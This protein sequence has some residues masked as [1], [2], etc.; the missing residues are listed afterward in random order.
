[1]KKNLKKRNKKGFTLIELV[2]VIAIL[3]ILAAI[4]VPVISGFIETANQSAD[5]ANARLVY[6]AAA[7][8]FAANNTASTGTLAASALTPYMG[9]ANYPEAKSTTFKGPFTAQVFADGSIEVLTTLAGYNPAI[10]KLVVGF[11]PVS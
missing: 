3:G 7:M 9:T 6:Q 8:W 4:L 11:N 1:M 2:V 5:N 10:G